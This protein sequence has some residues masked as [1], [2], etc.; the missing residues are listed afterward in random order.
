MHV[1]CISIMVELMRFQ[2]IQQYDYGKIVSLFLDRL[3]PRL[4]I[5]HWQALQWSKDVNVIFQRVRTGRH[6]IGTLAMDF[7]KREQIFVYVVT[8][9][10]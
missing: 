1:L 6:Q 7:Q 5:I 3:K 8:L 4:V 2:T 9:T 10:T